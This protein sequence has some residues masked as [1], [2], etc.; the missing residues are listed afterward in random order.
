[1][2]GYSWMKNKKNAASNVE[3]RAELINI[4]KKKQKLPPENQGRKV[5]YLHTSRWM[6]VSLQSSGQL[7]FTQL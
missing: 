1:M 5:T 2:G 3:N 4:N 6:Y 7:G